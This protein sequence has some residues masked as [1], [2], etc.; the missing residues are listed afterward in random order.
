[1]LTPALFS[2]LLLFPVPCLSRATDLERYDPRSEFA[3]G[4]DD[5]GWVATH[6]DPAAAASTAAAGHDDMPDLDEAPT[7]AAAGS[8]GG[9]GSGGPAAPAAAGGV[10]DD[11]PDIDDLEIVE[12]EDEVQSGE[13]GGGCIKLTAQAAELAWG[14]LLGAFNA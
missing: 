12:P 5:E 10:E 3:L 11:V 2:C 6:Q 1:M 9:E 14:L 7:A 4:G 8:S 13:A